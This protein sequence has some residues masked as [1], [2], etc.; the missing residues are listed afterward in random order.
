[1]GLAALAPGRLIR[2][3]AVA[4][5]FGCSA[6]L[7]ACVP[8]CLRACVPACLR[9]SGRYGTAVGRAATGTAGGVHGFLPALTSFIG[10]AGAVDE[11]AGLVDE[12]RLV[13]VTGPGEMGKTR[14]WRS[15]WR[16]RES[17]QPAKPAA[18]H[19]DEERAGRDCPGRNTEYDRLAARNGA[20]SPTRRVRLS[21]SLAWSEP[22]GLPIM[23]ILSRRAVLNTI[24]ADFHSR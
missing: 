2:L 19:R 4:V 20:G 9:A 18:S 24:V 17:S 23:C 3:A 1:V 16:R 10:R 12:S 8:A 13:T 15:S 21:G 7:R 14:R 6:C 11:V 22:P 5:L